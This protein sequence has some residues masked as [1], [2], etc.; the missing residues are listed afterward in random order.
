MIGDAPCHGKKYTGDL[1]DHFPDGSPE[2]LNIEDLMR[3]YCKLDIEFSM[4]KLSENVDTMV[5]AMRE[6]HQEIDV[7]D[8]SVENMKREI[9]DNV[10]I[11]SESGGRGGVDALYSA[12]AFVGAD[13][14]VDEGECETYEYKGKTGKY[15]GKYGGGGGGGGGAPVEGKM[16]M[17]KGFMKEAM[18]H[19]FRKFAVAGTKAAVVNYKARK[20]AGPMKFKGKCATMDEEE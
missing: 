18:D 3:E 12:A 1:D 13:E 20:A 17:K 11:A 19:E 9:V 4:I 7:K 10:I 15:G 6:N 14:E 2:G 8:M 16:K 5:Q